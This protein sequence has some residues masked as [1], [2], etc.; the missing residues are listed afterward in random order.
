[1]VRAGATA[2]DGDAEG[3]E[4]EAGR[5]THGSR[6]GRR[7]W[8]GWT[9]ADCSGRRSSAGRARSTGGRATVVCSRGRKLSASSYSS[10]TPRRL[11]RGGTPSP[12]R[13]VVHA[14]VP[15]APGCDR[16]G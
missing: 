11:D 10:L 5:R 8:L 7:R 15:Q 13:G 1:M 16:G 12:N 4:Q 2:V 9:W 14:Q 3:G 6:S